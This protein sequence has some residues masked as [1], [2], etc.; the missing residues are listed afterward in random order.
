M[1]QEAALKEAREKGARV[2]EYTYSKPEHVFAVEDRLLIVKKLIV[3]FDTFAALHPEDRSE[4][5]REATLDALCDKGIDARMFQRS[6]PKVFAEVCQRARTVQEQAFVDMN[7]RVLI[8]SLERL[9]R[10]MDTHGCLQPD[11]Q[12]LIAQT[13]VRAGLRPATSKELEAKA[14]NKLQDLAAR[15]VVEGSDTTFEDTAKL[16]K[17]DLSE[18]GP[19]RIHQPLG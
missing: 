1:T 5:L 8:W 3:L 14:S 2:L 9:K 12:A 13:F 10:D 17:L 19:T 4:T 16:G 6:C 11:T 15:P 18:L 7:R